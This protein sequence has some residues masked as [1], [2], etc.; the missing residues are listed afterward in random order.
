MRSRVALVSL[1]ALL[2]CAA[3]PAETE[4]PQAAPSASRIEASREIIRN[5][6]DR[7][8]ALRGYQAHF[9][10]DE[11][12]SDGRL[13]K[14]R[15]FL[16]FSKPF[17]I[18]MIWSEGDRKGTQLIYAKDKNDDKM[19]V[20]LPGLLFSFIGPV[21]VATDDP[22]VQK[23]QKHSIKR[24][25]IGFFIE[26]FWGDFERLESQG[27]IEVRGIEEGVEVAGERG[28]LIDLELHDM[29]ETYPRK[30]A[31]FSAETGLPIEIRLYKPEDRLVETFR[32]LDIVAD[33][34]ADDEVFKKIA[35]PALFKKY[36][37]SAS[38]SS[39]SV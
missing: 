38:P 39:A 13:K 29:D 15:S 27:A 4:L 21:T 24:A 23:D 22:R 25:G 37:E 31:V 35:N 19:I 33:P 3:A 30:A 12:G 11:L 5:A 1:A 18:Y 32:Y 20:Q 34:R 7:Y 6:V 36:V 26:D 17:A 28:T 16:K 8:R 10:K 9:E 2:L 14:E